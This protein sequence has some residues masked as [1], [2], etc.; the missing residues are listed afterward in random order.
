[1]IIDGHAHACGNYFDEKRI[2]TELKKE[3]IDMVVLCPG[4]ANSKRNYI[5]PMLCSLT[6]NYDICY[7]VNKFIQFAIKTSKMAEHTGDENK[8]IYELAKLH[9]DKIIQAY[10]VNPLIKDCIKKLEEDYKKY[11]FKMI[12]M[13]QCWNDIDI[14]SHSVK[15]VFDYAREK[16]LPIFIHLKS[17]EQVE[18]FIELSNLYLDVT[19]IIAHMIGFKEI[20]KKTLNNNIY[21]DIS[22]P[23][24]IREEL[25][26]EALEMIGS[27]RL[28]LGS[29]TPY[30]TNNIKININRINKYCTSINDK[31]N[32]MYENILKILKKV[33]N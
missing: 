28:I 25:F 12:K 4:E 18:R 32:I 31:K 8:R 30:G 19:V 20:S 9:P 7:K 11:K 15:A 14:L 29:D 21:Y 3:K 22:S 2:L 10:W 26:K 16:R 1:M 5:Y 23:Q 24:L 13:H 33:E 17:K 27:S 6:K